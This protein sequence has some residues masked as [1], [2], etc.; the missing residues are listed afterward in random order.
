MGKNNLKFKL[1]L[2]LILLSAIVFTSL[3]ILPFLKIDIKAKITI[4]IIIIVVGEI[5]FWSGGV[6]VG[7]EIFSKFKSYL[8]PKNWLKKIL[9]RKKND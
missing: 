7:K 4:T 2:F 1:G 8:N 3:L 5:L 9:E 6:L